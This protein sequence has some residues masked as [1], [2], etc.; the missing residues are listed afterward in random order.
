MNF[1]KW[2]K[3]IQTA[4]Y[5]GARTVYTNQKH[6]L[7]FVLEWYVL[8]IPFFAFHFGRWSYENRLRDF[9]YDV[10][11]LQGKTGKTKMKIN[12]KINKLLRNIFVFL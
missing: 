12:K 5:N 10:F 7:Q 3:S 11:R 4:G 1:K 2:V 9:Q 8:F 6:L